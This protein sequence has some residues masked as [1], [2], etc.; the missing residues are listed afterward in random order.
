MQH[1]EA[2]LH[3][4]AKYDHASVITT[5]AG[6]K[7]D[8]NIRGKVTGVC[9]NDTYTAWTVFHYDRHRMKTRHCT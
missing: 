8:V 6:T 9:V 3:L 5:L 4:A 1:G 2:A 7:M